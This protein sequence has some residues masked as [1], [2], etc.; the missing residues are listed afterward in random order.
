MQGALGASGEMCKGCQG[1]RG[2]SVQGALGHK[3]GECARRVGVQAVK[4]CAGRGDAQTRSHGWE[5]AQAAPGPVAPRSSRPGPPQH[6]GGGNRSGWPWGGSGV[7]SP[8]AAP[9][10]TSPGCHGVWVG[11]GRRQKSER[12]MSKSGIFPGGRRW[13]DGSLRARRRS[14]A[15]N[16]P[17]RSPKRRRGQPRPRAAPTLS[18]GEFCL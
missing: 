5:R 11:R 9:C 1:A 14:A 4:V 10:P 16:R 17:K 18:R 2:G 7:G 12:S 3:W 13:E 6:V 8:P 15:P